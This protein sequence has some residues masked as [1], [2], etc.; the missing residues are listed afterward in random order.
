LRH[1]TQGRKQHSVLKHIGVVARVEGVSV[2]EH[3]L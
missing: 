2:T 3:P 1:V